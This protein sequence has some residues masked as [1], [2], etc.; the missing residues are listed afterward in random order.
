L[1]WG[2]LRVFSL[3]VLFLAGCGGGEPAPATCA[4]G[5]GLCSH[6]VNRVLVPRI[7]AAGFVPE[8]GPAL[9][10]C[11]RMTLDLVGRIPTPAELDLCAGESADAMAQ[12]LMSLPDYDAHQRRLWARKLGLDTS[13]TVWWQND[14]MDQLVGRMIAGELSY[15]AFAS[16][17][18]SHPA[19]FV[20]ARL[21]GDY[22][23]T[24]YQVFLGRPARQD[25]IA[26]IRPLVSGTSTQRQVCD[27]RSTEILYQ[28][29]LV[30]EAEGERDPDEGPCGRYCFGEPHEGLGNRCGCP[31]LEDPEEFGQPIFGCI[32]TAFGVPVDLGVSECDEDEYEDGSIFEA[33]VDRTA[34]DRNVCEDIDADCRDLELV[35]ADDEER[36][37]TARPAAPAGELVK[38]RFASLGDALVSRDDF[39][40]AAVDDELRRILGWWQ[41]S[42]RQPDTDLPDVRAV[43]TAH[44]RATGSL[45][46]VQRLL[47]TSLLY[48]MPA[49][50]LK[51]DGTFE[52]DPLTAPAWTA[53]PSKFLSGER[54][55]DAAQVAVGDELW[56]ACDRR[57]ASTNPWLGFE[58]SVLVGEVDETDPSFDLD[59]VY[60]TFGE[61]SEELD[62]FEGYL[63]ERAAYHVLGSEMGGC[64]PS[65]APPVANLAIV[66]AQARSATV[67]CAL[68]RGVAPEGTSAAD[69][70][71]A[72]L[73]L[74]A[75][76][77]A[78]RF[79]SAPAGGADAQA[80]ASDMAA[81]VDDGACGDALVAARWS[82]ARVLD[83]TSFAIY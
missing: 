41:T 43:L 80:L 72:G 3:V 69:T 77:Q 9:E 73:A 24:M 75:D 63:Y 16:Q 38:D 71:E 22:E 65:P 56:G 6:P 34:G 18:L 36:F 58:K 31:I 4:E 30:E 32:G 23:S 64:R 2:V 52:V 5:A 39:W 20:P 26:A 59:W 1:R 19:F 83:S 82:C 81:C 14:H 47:V 37:I 78:R 21:Q 51:S 48:T 40:E 44:L 8:Q 50:G 13:Y 15:D 7:E 12:R 28:Q 49:Q 35:Y 54:W 27:G 66:S 61:D 29:C 76:H 45:R 25:E 57:F 74:I 55:L 67:L 68:G 62:E 33:L 17:A 42:L 53:G 11:R 60:D 10:L 79:L 46:E 70:S